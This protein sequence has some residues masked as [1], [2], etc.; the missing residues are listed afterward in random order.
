M[1]QTRRDFLRR[2]GLAVTSAAA[3]ATID[4]LTLTSAMSQTGGPYKALVCIFFGGGSDSNNMV[5]PVGNNPD[6]YPLY[7][8]ARGPAR[9]S[10]GFTQ[11]ALTATNITP[12]NPGW[13][14]PF[15][16][17][18]N[19]A[20][21]FSTYDS[22]H[23][24][25]N[26]NRAA[27]I[28]NTGPLVRPLTGP[29]PRQ[30]YISNPNLRP[31]QLFSH[32]D[33]VQIYQT[34]SAQRHVPTGWGGRFADRLLADGITTSPI[35]FPIVTTAAGVAHYTIGT[36]TRPLAVPGSGNLGGVLA[37]G[38]YGTTPA[39]VARRDAFDISRQTGRGNN[40]VRI[41]GDIM[42]QAIQLSD[43]LRVNP[44]FTTT[45]PATNLGNQLLQVARI[46][47][48][49]ADLQ[50][51]SNRLNRQ[52]FYVSIGGFDTHNNQLAGQGGL[53]TQL[54]QAMSSFYQSTIELGIANQVTTFT[55]SDFNRTF[56][57]ASP[58]GNVGSDHAWGAHHLVIGGAVRGRY[59]YGVNGPN[60][61]PFPI[62]RQRRDFTE[63]EAIQDTGNR[64]SWI[65]TTSVEQY[66]NTLAAWFGLPQDDTTLNYI[67][68]GLISGGFSPRNLGFML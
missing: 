67:F 8:L 42:E 24:L 7:S 59:F 49:N 62:L 10:L 65:P 11:A 48:I 27:V 5:I 30:T 53:F 41:T 3:A 35:N 19:F 40:L 58:G 61:T 54:S 21:R 1:N 47:K 15:A 57:P 9:G 51:P 63:A 29:S 23:T 31:Y 32:S 33:Q 64:G 28:C 18:P 17:H 34:S 25:W 16:F 26:N 52:I 14:R 13:G 39:E 37:L 2:T 66:A 68:P 12:L 38:G 43:I 20:Q 60:G 44:T 22:I 55:M 4:Q 45:F 56:D 50:P 46:I 36:T 6:E